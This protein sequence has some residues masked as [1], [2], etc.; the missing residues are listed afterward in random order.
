MVDTKYS[1][2]PV[3]AKRHPGPQHMT[4]DI[5]DLVATTERSGYILGCDAN[6][7]RGGVC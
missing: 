1:N 3:P 6:L 2:D 7:A 5:L 4:H